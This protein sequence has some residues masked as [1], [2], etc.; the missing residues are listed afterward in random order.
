MEFLSV[1]WLGT[2]VW[3]WLSFAGIVIVL[4]AF[5]L[6]F[7]HILENHE[8]VQCLAWWRVHVPASSTSIKGTGFAKRMWRAAEV[9]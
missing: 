1:D 6:G 2:P 9:R 5:D 3:F 7:L 4:T 8:I